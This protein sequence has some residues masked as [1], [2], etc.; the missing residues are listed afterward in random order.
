MPI[1]VDQT[2]AGKIVIAIRCRVDSDDWKYPQPGYKSSNLILGQKDSLREHM[3]Y[4]LMGNRAT[5][6]LDDLVNVCLLF[7]ALLLYS[8]Q[9]DRTEYL[10]SLR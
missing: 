2:A 3:W 7:G 5:E 10:F 6:W 4:S 8:T 9:R 1:P